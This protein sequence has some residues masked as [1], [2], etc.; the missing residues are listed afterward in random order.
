[1]QNKTEVIDKLLV[2]CGLTPR[3]IASKKEQIDPRIY[4]ALPTD[5]L[6]GFG[7]MGSAGVGKSCAIAW[8]LRHINEIRYDYLVGQAD[9]K[10][11]ATLEETGYFNPKRFDWIYWPDCALAHQ[12]ANRFGTPIKGVYP[13]AVQTLKD[14]PLLVLDDLGRERGSIDSYTNQI[15]DSVVNYRYEHN[16]PTIWTTNLEQEA[17]IAQYGMPML[18]RLTG[19]SPAAGWVQGD[20][21]RGME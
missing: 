6:R 1:M 13:F 9:G 11:I 20:S 19:M 16:L 3:L 17:F 18:D 8:W 10:E 12:D 7:M 21:K 2:E 15:L 5:K 4:E 14:S